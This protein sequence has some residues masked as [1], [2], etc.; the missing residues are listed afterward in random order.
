MPASSLPLSLP[1]LALPILLFLPAGDFPFEAGLSVL[2]GVAA[3]LFL[4]VIFPFPRT[5]G[6]ES[7]G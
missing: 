4:A 3:G 6:M 7:L 2:F 1:P 5:V